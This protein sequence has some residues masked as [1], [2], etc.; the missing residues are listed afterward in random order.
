MADGVRQNVSF[1]TMVRA[2]DCD[3]QWSW[4][5]DAMDASFPDFSVEVCDGTPAYIES[6]VAGWFRAPGY[7]CPWGS[8]VVA[9]EERP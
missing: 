6:D 4:S 1:P 7:W 5:V 2:T 9:V 8:K 3:S